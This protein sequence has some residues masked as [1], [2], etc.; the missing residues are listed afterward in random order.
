VNLATDQPDSFFVATSIRTGEMSMHDIGDLAS[1]VTAAL[2]IKNF[3]SPAVCQATLARIDDGD[4]FVEEYDRDRVDPPIARFGPVINDFKAGHDI[5]ESYWRAALDARDAWRVAIAEETDPM[6]VTLD[7]LRTVWPGAVRLA[8]VGGRPLFAGSIREINHGA[9]IHFDDVRREY[10][11]KLIDG[12]PPVVQV[13]FN[14]WLSVPERGGET[15][16][17]RRR[18]RPGDEGRRQGYGVAAEAVE[19]SPYLRVAAEAGDALLFDPRN[20]HAVAPAVGGRRVALAFF[21]V[22]TARGDLLLWS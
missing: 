18:W 2:H 16:I 14:A 17:W 13:A 5:D 22:L 4:L 20:Y 3:L 6:R 19:G 10:G 11:P 21:M 1:G 15:T 7:R 9:L 12:G 8:T